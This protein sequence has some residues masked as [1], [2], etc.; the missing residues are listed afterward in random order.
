MIKAAEKLLHDPNFEVGKFLAKLLAKHLQDNYFDYADD[1][2]V[3]KYLPP[4]T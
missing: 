4:L 1:E 2:V 3:K